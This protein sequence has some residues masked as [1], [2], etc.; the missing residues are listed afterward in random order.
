MEAYFAGLT[1]L[2]K[3]FMGCAVFG[4]GLFILRMV[5][6][7][8]GADSSDADMDVD[9]D[10]DMDA[11]VDASDSADFDDVEIDAGLRLLTF[12]GMTAFVMMFGLTGYAVSRNSGTG[13]AFTVA[14]GCLAG[15]AGMWLM[16]KG[17]ALMNSLQSSGNMNVKDAVGQEGTV[18]LTIPAEGPGR[19]QLPVS[20]RLKVMS[21]TSHDKVEIKTGTRVS[22]VAVVN[23]RV[24]G[25]R[26][27]S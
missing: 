25:V 24:L 21:A 27:A 3:V 1:G 8:V 7:L 5:L 13:T 20:G 19:V 4:G 16:A 11:D 26:K 14:L 18:Y 22:V 6:M 17:F 10:I 15:F 9:M 23:E 2:E 12:Q